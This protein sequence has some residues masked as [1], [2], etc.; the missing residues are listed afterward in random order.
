MNMKKRV[1]VIHSTR[2]ICTM[3]DLN[4]LNGAIPEKQQIV[5]HGIIQAENGTWQLWAC[6]RGL[7][8]GKLL[9]GWEG[10]SLDTEN[11]RHA[12]VKMRA[13]AEV[14]E[15]IKP[16]GD[17][18]L[19][20]PFFIKNKDQYLCFY[21]SGDIWVVQSADGVNYERVIPHR[22]SIPGG[23]DVMILK[24]AGLF[25]SYATTS[26]LEG[27]GYIESATS[28]DLID[29]TESKIVSK[30]GKGGRGVVDAESPFVVFVDGYFYLFRTSSISFKTVVYR[31]EDPQ[32]FGIDDDSKLVAELDI[33]IV[34]LFQYENQWYI[35]HIS[36]DF[37]A[38][39]LSKIDWQFES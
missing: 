6:L 7:K 28:K 32:A 23:R 22:T 31:S 13:N 2:T 15:L 29:W 12:G 1:P 27:E 25:Y 4:E 9:Y 11:W 34:E 24:H 35:T 39:L 21:H 30:G 10:D 20:A 19:G 8:V 33:K 37:Q 18:R 3:P 5:D 26:T 38:V 14:G 17:E 36:E 16:G